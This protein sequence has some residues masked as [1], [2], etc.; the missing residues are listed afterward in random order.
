MDLVNSHKTMENW[1]VHCHNQ[2]CLGDSFSNERERTRFKERKNGGMKQ[3][4]RRK[5]REETETVRDRSGVRENLGRRLR[6]PQTFDKCFIKKRIRCC[7]SLS[8]NVIVFTKSVIKK[9]NKKEQIKENIIIIIKR[10]AYWTW[11]RN[12][13]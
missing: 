1:S 3:G 6:L 8:C 7:Y 13:S 10:Y 9:E 12:K 5:Q 2:S 11:T 4:Y